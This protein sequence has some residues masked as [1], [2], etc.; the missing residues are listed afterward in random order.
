MAL[1]ESFPSNGAMTAIDPD[2]HAAPAAQPR[3]KPQG[4]ASHLA[5]TLWRFGLG[6]PRE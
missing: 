4:W 2:G 6:G 5:L 1:P 3:W